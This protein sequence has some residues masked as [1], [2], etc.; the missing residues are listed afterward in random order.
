V[1]DPIENDMRRVGEP[2]PPAHLRP[3]VMARVS[4]AAEAGRP[5]R[6]SAPLQHRGRRRASPHFL[7]WLGALAGIAVSA[8]WWLRQPAEFAR[9]TSGRGLPLVARDLVEVAHPHTAALLALGLLLYLAGLFAPLRSK[10]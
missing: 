1:T 7:A 4:S 3:Q 2:R 8:A 9:W 10:H 5:A 6:V